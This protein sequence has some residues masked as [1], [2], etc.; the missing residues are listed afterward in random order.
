MIQ[1][2]KEATVPQHYKYMAPLVEA[3]KFVGGSATKNEVCEL[4]TTK[5]GLKKEEVYKE[6]VKSKNEPKIYNQIG[7]ARNVLACEGIIEK[8]GE[9]GVWTLTEKGLNSN[10]TTKELIRIHENQKERDRQRRKDKKEQCNLSHELPP[11]EEEEYEDEEYDGIKEPPMIVH[12]KDCNHRSELIDRLNSM[13]GDGF[14]FF[15]RDMLRKAGFTGVV[16]LGKVGDGGID[17]ICYWVINEFRKEKF[18]WQAKRCCNSISSPDVVNFRGAVSGRNS[19]NGIFITTGRFTTPAVEE[20]T[21]E[22]AISVEIFDGD[23]IVQFC[24]KHQLG[25]DLRPTYEIN[26]EF[27][28]KYNS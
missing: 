21:K 10:L 28:D 26:D 7:W 22:C 17:G 19:V 5:M 9:R 2:Q 18:Y 1:E 4:V 24:E 11:E 15:C 8:P 14:Q 25:L 16:V 13:S 23:N 3:L 12:Y 27:F 6:F 20:A